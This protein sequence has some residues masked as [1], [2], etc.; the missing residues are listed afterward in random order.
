[1]NILK[2]EWREQKLSAWAFGGLW[3]FVTAF[4]WA[5]SRDGIEG[6]YSLAF[7]FLC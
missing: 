2:R 3:V 7:L 1:M 5:P 4:L 6:V